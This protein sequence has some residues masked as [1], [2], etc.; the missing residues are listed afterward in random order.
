MNQ[1]IVVNVLYCGQGMT[2][3]VECYD[4]GDDKKPADYLVLVD[5]GG[6]VN[7]GS[8]A[9]QYIAD[10]VLATKSKKLDWLIISHQDG[11]HVRLLPYLGTK[12]KGKG[13]TV[14]SVFL[15]GLD[16]GQ[17][18]KDDVT[19][20][21]ADVNYAK[22]PRF[23]APP[24]SDYEGKKG[25][26][27]D[28]WPNL[29]KLV[30]HGDM[31]IRILTSGLDVQ[32]SRGDIRKNASSSVV[33]VDDGANTVVLPGDA[34]FQ[35]MNRINNIANLGNLLKPVLGLEIP[36]HGALRT[37]VENYAANR[38]PD[39]LDY[40]VVDT[41]V[42]RMQ[43]M[44]VVASAGAENTHRHPVEEVF[45]TFESYLKNS[46]GDHTYVAWDFATRQ[47]TY[48]IGVDKEEWSTV[49][50]I[51]NPQA[52]SNKNPPLKKRKITKPSLKLVTG[53][54]VLDLGPAAPA[55]LEDRVRFRPHG[56]IN[57]GPVAEPVHYAP[58]P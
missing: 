11:D 30:K 52:T 45:N 49:Q 58:A 43:P 26:K 24:R 31:Y 56:T 3:L 1:L 9:V 53:D 28:T 50:Q 10:K 48:F 23:N 5:C 41:F 37:A 44:E 2:T 47:W 34:T 20:F 25:K 16:W 35:T 15:G 32:T 17:G 54:V 8:A 13:A 33:V 42:Q 36:H 21:L 29:G 6:D 57:I 4:T 22:S 14:D 7:E 19:A 51:A 12:L 46:N 38:D 39:A 18:S 40:S 27:I 55:R